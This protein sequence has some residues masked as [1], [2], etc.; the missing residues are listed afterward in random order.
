L[1]VS[2]V[3]ALRVGAAKSVGGAACETVAQKIQ[4]YTPLILHANNSTAVEADKWNFV[5]LVFDTLGAASPQCY[6]IVKKLTTEIAKRQELSRS[7]ATKLI[8]EKISMAIAKGVAMQLA[9]SFINC[10]LS[11]GWDRQAK[12]QRC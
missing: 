11:S 3:H 9:S 10:N 7:D 4:H 6:E 5:P 1:D 2:I 8:W 12:H